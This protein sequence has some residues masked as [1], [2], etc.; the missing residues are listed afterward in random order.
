MTSTFSQWMPSTAP[1]I[2]AVALAAAYSS[3]SSISVK[4]CARPAAPLYMRYSLYEVTPK[5]FEHSASVSTCRWLVMPKCRPKSMQLCDAARSRYASN[6][7]RK[8]AVR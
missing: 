3:A 5:R 6:A 8:S 4:P 1:S 7:A 2:A